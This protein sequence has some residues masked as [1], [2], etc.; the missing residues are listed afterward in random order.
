MCLLF[1]APVVQY[2]DYGNYEKVDS[3]NVWNMELQYMQM[4]VQAICCSLAGVMP[5]E[6]TWPKNSNLDSYF[7]ADQFSCTFLSQ[8]DST[9]QVYSVKLVNGEKDVAEQLLADN[10]AK[11]GKEQS[12][13]IG[14]DGKLLCLLTVRC[15]V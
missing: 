10:L 5:L 6:E 3:G 11:E 15:I 7:D 4:P 9:S 12:H 2:V 14:I 1:T 8:L 13:H